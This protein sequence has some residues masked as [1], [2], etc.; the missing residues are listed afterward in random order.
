MPK[1]IKIINTSTK[2]L[3]CVLNMIVSTGAFLIQIHLIFW[4]L[5]SSI[6]VIKSLCL[7]YK[8]EDVQISSSIVKKSCII[9]DCDYSIITRLEH[10]SKI[11]IILKSVVFMQHWRYEIWPF[12]NALRFKCRFLVS[13]WYFGVTLI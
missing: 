9:P 6:F 1:V 12:F 13:R 4:K 10:L 5:K 2:S 8:I 7:L 3:K 11:E